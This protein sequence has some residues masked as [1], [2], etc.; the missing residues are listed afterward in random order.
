MGPGES[1]PTKN[2]R[3]LSTPITSVPKRNAGAVGKRPSGEA[4]GEARGDSSCPSALLG[5]IGEVIMVGRVRRSWLVFGRGENGASVT[6]DIVGDAIAG[7]RLLT[8]SAV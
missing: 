8:Y 5:R 4:N 2:L 7:A 6:A 1:P 3:G